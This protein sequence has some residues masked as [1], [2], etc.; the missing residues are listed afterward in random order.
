[1]KFTWDEVKN[2][3]NI[4][5]HGIDFETAQ[6]VFSD[7]HVADFTER[8]VVGGEERWLAFGSL[9][10]S[11]LL[12]V[13]YTTMYDGDDEVI[14]II[15]ARKA[16]QE[17]GENMLTEK[18]K[19]QLKALAEM[20]DDQIDYSDIPETTDEQW[21][22]AVR[23]MTKHISIR[24]SASD[25]EIADKLAAEKGLPYQTYIKS[26]LHESLVAENAKANTKASKRP[27]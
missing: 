2:R 11:V 14:R 6:E 19:A 25:L 9:D 21:K 27:L 8:I 12:A 23:G 4:A 24:V 10:G 15:S 13:S 16:M 26:L 7:P 22:T 5:K 20:P 17:K 3:S 18:Q 1:L